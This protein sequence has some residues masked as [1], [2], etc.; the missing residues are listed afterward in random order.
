MIDVQLL[1]D[2][3]ELWPMAKANYAALDHL[4][5]REIKESAP[6]VMAMFNPE[7]VRSTAA[8]ID[9][10]SV[11]ARPC[12]LCARNRPEEQRSI[13]WRD[14]DVLVN[15][16]PIFRRHLTIVSRHHVAQEFVGREAD[17]YALALEL[18]GFSVFFN[19]ARCG[20]S[21]PDHMHFQAGDGLFAPS[22]LQTE[23]DG[24]DETTLF[25]D[26]GT[27]TVGASEASGRLV[28]HVVA[29]SERGAVNLISRLF[30]MR[31]IDGE[32]MNIVARARESGG[33][34][35]FYVVPRRAFR[36]WQYTAEGSDN[37]LVS[38]A[39]VEVSGIFILPRLADFEALTAEM[40][41]DIMGQVCYQRDT[42][43]KL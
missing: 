40:A 25:S 2:M 3:T 10:T 14:Y 42:S 1:F 36:P 30:A 11:A 28:Y 27:G 31:A 18:P 39:A 29:R 20:A 7:R 13:V 16:F 33:V 35:D 5:F 22:P 8:K 17:I 26:A 23:V 21:A 38:P 12:F 32:M 15:P 41:V 19:G 6:R 43:L 24:G 4:K 9:K 34:V 37:L